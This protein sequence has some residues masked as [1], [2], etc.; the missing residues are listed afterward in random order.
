MRVLLLVQKEQRV[1]LER[2]YDGIAGASN[3][4]THWLS[5]KEQANLRYYF[6]CNIDV[7]K[8]DRVVLFLRIKKEMRQVSFLRSIPNLVFLE[9]DAYQNYIKCKYTDKF[10]RYYKKIPWVRVI[11]SGAVVTRRLQEEGVDAVFV[12]KGYDQK[13]LKNLNQPRDIELGFIGST[14]SEAYS[15]R[16][17]FLGK[18]SEEEKLI[19]R[20]TKSGDEYLQTLNRIQFFVSADIGM[21]EYMIKNFEAMACGCTLFTYNQ[22]KEENEALGFKDMENVVLYSSIDEFKNKLN[23]LRENKKLANEIAK[24]GLKFVQENYSFEKVGQRVVK[25]L[26]PRLRDRSGSSYWQL[27]RNKIGW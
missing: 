22:G 19:V 27:L 25:A 2:L 26:E 3:C 12:P 21:G 20:R 24:Q 7:N 1:I 10:S 4:E 5:D 11:S 13:L 6:M 15:Q 14:K 8:Y 16:R 17:E 23:Y 9:H 18:L